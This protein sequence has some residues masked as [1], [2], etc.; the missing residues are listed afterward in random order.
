MASKKPK[1]DAWREVFTDDEI[2]HRL[3]GM[4]S[5]SEFINILPTVR[6]AACANIGLVS[7]EVMS[8]IK[9]A[10]LCVEQKGKHFYE[11]F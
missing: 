2:V 1:L 4:C 5:P 3:T 10:G 9:S 7:D 8:A 11:S 6:A